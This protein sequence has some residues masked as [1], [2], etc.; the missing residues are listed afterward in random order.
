MAKKDKQPLLTGKKRKVIII[1]GV[2]VLVLVAAGAGIAIRWWQDTAQPGGTSETTEEET[3][4]LPP[5][6]DDLQNLRTEGDQ[7]T[8]DQELATALENPDYDDPTRALLY[9]Q[10][11]NAAYDNRDF[12]AALEAY[13]QADEL[14]P[15]SQTAQ[16]VGF[17]YQELGN[18]PKAIEFYQL[19]IERLDPANILYEA[20]KA[21][22]E[23]RIRQLQ[24]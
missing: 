19:T 12:N 17:A 2:I 3:P 5:V 21:Y 18:N 10:Q 24:G 22:F 13:L 1:T 14:D 7:E 9:I 11:G 23:E 20:D 4:T 16:L 6:V 8:F 15:S